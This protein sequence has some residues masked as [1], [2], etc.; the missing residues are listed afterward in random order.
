MSL[1]LKNPGMPAHATVAAYLGLFVSLA[2][3]G[4]Y[5]ATQI[6]AGQLKAPIARVVA[7]QAAVQGVQE[8]AIAMC[9]KNER[10]LSGGGGWNSPGGTVRMARPYT[11]TDSTGVATGFQVVGDN[12]P[13]AGD[14]LEAWA[15]CLP[16]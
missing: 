3:G 12:A 16:K 9:K 11:L 10:L 13:V 5:A 1:S 7:H 4:A 8:S 6:G 2:T 15:V 14:T